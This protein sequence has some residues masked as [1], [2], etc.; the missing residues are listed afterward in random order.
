MWHNLYRIATYSSLNIVLGEVFESLLC[1]SHVIS[2]C[3]M[4]IFGMKRYSIT[5]IYGYHWSAWWTL[6]TMLGSVNSL[7]STVQYVQ[8]RMNLDAFYLLFFFLFG[9]WVRVG[10]MFYELVNA[11]EHTVA[12]IYIHIVITNP[13]KAIC[14]LSRYY[15]Q[16]PSYYKT[17]DFILDLSIVWLLILPYYQNR[18]IITKVCFSACWV[19]WFAWCSQR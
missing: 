8:V 6:L 5:F 17:A 12:Y 11:F 3:D 16:Y 2:S 9:G 10:D 13:D 4:H 15:F 19:I 14:C 18:F 1:G 7:H